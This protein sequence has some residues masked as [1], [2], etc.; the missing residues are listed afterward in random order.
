VT[1]II[2]ERI[3]FGPKPQGG[4]RPSLE[5]SKA[6]EESEI[7]QEPIDEISLDQLPEQSLE[8]EIKPE[9]LPF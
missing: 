5:L 6:T 8:D 9:D 1:E 2:C 7:I 4:T 3:Q